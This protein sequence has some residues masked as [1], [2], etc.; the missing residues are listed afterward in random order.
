MTEKNR[1][2][3]ELKERRL[4]AGT[5]IGCRPRRE[6]PK[7]AYKRKRRTTKAERSEL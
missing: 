2:K 1:R 5:F 6:I 3:A 4:K 7:T